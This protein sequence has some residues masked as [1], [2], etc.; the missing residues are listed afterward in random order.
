MSIRGVDPTNI[1]VRIVVGRRFGVVH[2]QHCSVSGESELPGFV[3]LGTSRWGTVLK[4]LAF[5]NIFLFRKPPRS[6]QKNWIRNSLAS[7]NN[8]FRLLRVSLWFL[9]SFL[10]CEF[11]ILTFIKNVLRILRKREVLASFFIW[12]CFGAF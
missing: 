11:S 7:P 6:Y 4:I 3:G 8:N 9:F 10:L 1:L 12:V 5:K 2:V